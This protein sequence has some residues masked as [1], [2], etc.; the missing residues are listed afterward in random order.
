MFEAIRAGGWRV[1]AEDHEDAWW[2]V[3]IARAGA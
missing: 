1:D 3:R 2:S